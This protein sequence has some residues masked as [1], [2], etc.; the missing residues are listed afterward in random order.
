MKR[1]Y[2]TYTIEEFFRIGYLDA[3]TDG[4]KE[5]DKI[6]SGLIPYFNKEKILERTTS[7]LTGYK[8]CLLELELRKIDAYIRFNYENKAFSSNK[9]YPFKK[10][11]KS[12]ENDS[13][14][15]SFLVLKKHK[16]T[17]C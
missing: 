15:E 8:I 5:T 1:E 4:M 2:A 3:L 12:L 14:N 16:E 11:Y 10:F 6:I 7:Y 17:L 9:K 13:M